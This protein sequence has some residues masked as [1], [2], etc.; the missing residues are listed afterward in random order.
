MLCKNMWTAM[1]RE[2]RIK[3]TQN[4]QK[5]SLQRLNMVACIVVTTDQFQRNVSYKDWRIATLSSYDTKHLL[6]IVQSS[7]TAVTEMLQTFH[8]SSFPCSFLISNVTF[9]NQWYCKSLGGGTCYTYYLTVN[10]KQTKLKSKVF[11]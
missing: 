11:I 8:H 10:S 1:G 4:F 9:G 6:L 7:V 5:Q 3:Y 2:K